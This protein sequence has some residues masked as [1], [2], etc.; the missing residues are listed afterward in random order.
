MPVC[1]CV[2]FA[3]LADI[4]FALCF[5]KRSEETWNVS[6][7]EDRACVVFGDGGTLRFLI[8]SNGCYGLYSRAIPLTVKQPG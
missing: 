6:L 7:R 5:F 3:S 1:V 2:V 4:L 8:V